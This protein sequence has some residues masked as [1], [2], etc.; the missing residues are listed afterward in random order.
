MK[1]YK[2]KVVEGSVVFRIRK[3]KVPILI[4]VAKELKKRLNLEE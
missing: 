3:T 1:E 4:E 2:D